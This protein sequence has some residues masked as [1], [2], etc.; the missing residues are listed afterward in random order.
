MKTEN[1]LHEKTRAL[2]VVNIIVASLL[3]LTIFN[4]IPTWKLSTKGMQKFEGSYI[5][6]YYEKEAV[7]AKDVFKLADAEA[8]VI[9]SKLGFTEKQDINIYIYDLQSTMQAKKYGY[10]G[11]LLNL[12]WYIGDN[13]GT[14]VILT[15]PANPGKVHTYSNNKYAALHE[16]VHAYI[17]ILNPKIKLWLTEGTALYLTNGE[18]FN[19]SLLSNIPSYS[20]IQTQNPIKFSNMGGYDFANTYIEYIDNTY[21]WD[22]VLDLIKTGDYEGVF[23][24]SGE[25]IYSEWVNYLKS[26]Q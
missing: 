19:T 6:V 25:E 7:A 17:S 21:G 3:I 20:D 24:K 9:A 11:P 12:D 13:I 18:K 22:E 5:N 10:I 16:M 1:Q 26:N 14:N 4:F 8:A 23:G 2:Q 15:S